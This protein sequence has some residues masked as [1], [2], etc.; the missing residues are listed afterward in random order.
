MRCVM[1]I[2]YGSGMPNKDGVGTGLDI[3]R[4]AI[5]KEKIDAVVREI[6]VFESGTFKFWRA[7]FWKDGVREVGKRG[8]NC[9]I[10]AREV[11]KK[12]ARRLECLCNPKAYYKGECELAAEMG[13]LDVWTEREWKKAKISTKKWGETFRIA[14]ELRPISLRCTKLCTV[15]NWEWLRDIGTAPMILRKPIPNDPR[16]SPAPEY[17]LTHKTNPASQTSPNFPAHFAI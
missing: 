15:L 12:V 4:K 3:I 17:Q 7:N 1:V 6:A 10:I 5:V 9:T 16:L 13:I 2:P 8:K 14:R 11:R